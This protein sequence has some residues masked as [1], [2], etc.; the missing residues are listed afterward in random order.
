MWICA[1]CHTE[2]RDSVSACMNCGMMRSAGRFGS[3]PVQME[4]TARAPRVSNP[5]SLSAAQE[6]PARTASARTAY[7]PPAAD[8]TPAR[9]RR[10]PAAVLARAVGGALCVLLPLLTA[11]LAWR[12]FEPLSRALLPLLLSQGAAEWAQTVCYAALALIAVLVSLLPGLW[13]LLL[14]RPRISKKREMDGK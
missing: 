13:T 14:A 7:Q 10:H 4:N 8:W 3:A 1:H 6:P 12:Q 2:N 11:L 9:P 5:A